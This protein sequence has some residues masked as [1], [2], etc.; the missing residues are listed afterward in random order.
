M[1]KIV[2]P[3]LMLFSI[4][5]FSQKTSTNEEKKLIPSISFNFGYQIPGGDLASRFGNNSNIGGSFWLKLPSNII[6]SIDGYYL[7]G[8]ELKEEATNIF[9][10]IKNSDGNII[11]KYGKFS[12]ILLSERGYYFGIK[13]GKVFNIG[14]K[15]KNSGIIATFGV[16]FIEHHIN[17]ENDGNRTP[18]ILD[19]YKKGYDKLVNGIALQQFVGYIYYGKRNLTNLV[20]GVEFTQGFT[21]SR[22]SY[23]F[24]IMKYDNKNRKD[25][26]YGVKIGWLIP[27]LKRAPADFYYNW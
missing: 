15:N 17:I 26:Y 3:I 22:R 27:F 6:F 23:D 24:S 10:G 19:E 2:F 5:M 13:S 25:L 18:Q 11:D 4:A 9:D 1:T 12:T 20:I 21:K 16:G 8:N 14:S 7:F